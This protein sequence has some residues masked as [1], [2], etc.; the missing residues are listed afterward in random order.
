MLIRSQNKESEKNVNPPKTQQQI[1]Q[2][3]GNRNIHLHRKITNRKIHLTFCILAELG[4]SF[5]FVCI[6]K[7]LKPYL[8]LD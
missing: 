8:K 4:Y 6:K 7:F 1:G 2:K 5:D 3:T